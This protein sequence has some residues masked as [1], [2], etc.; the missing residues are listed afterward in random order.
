MAI[1]KNT[2]DEYNKSNAAYRENNSTASARNNLT[3]LGAQ[4]PQY[5]KSYADQLENIYGRL[6]N[7]ESC[8][9]D[10]QNDAAFRRYAD[11][12]N[13]LSGLA[14]AGNQQQAQQLTGGY[15]STYAPDVAEQG[16]ARLQSGV[17]GAQ[18]GFYNA[19]RQ[20]YMAENDRLNNMYSATA[21][22]RDAELEQ[23]QKQ[24][25]A[26]NNRYQMAQQRYADERDF[27]YNQYKDTRNYNASQYEFA[28]KQE[29]FDSELAQKETEYSRD[30]ELK[31][32]EVYTKLAAV[33]CAE[34]NEAKNNSGMKAYLDG[35]VEAG[36]I[37]Q[38]MADNLYNQYKYTVTSSG[39]GGGRSS[40]GGK[41]S[42]SS[43][44]YSY[45]GGD[46]GTGGSGGG[47][48]SGSDKTS[49]WIVAHDSIRNRHTHTLNGHESS[50]T[51]DGM[52][53]AIQSAYQSGEL[54][55]QEAAYLLNY[56]GLSGQAKQ[57]SSKGNKGG[58]GGYNGST[59]R[60][61]QER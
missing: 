14:I 44:S 31:S 2:E 54:S 51:A 30:Y 45:D 6:K 33:K 13:A 49:D 18:P 26:Y 36:K 27:G 48:F 16:L 8:N 25:D 7:G 60:T 19:A 38:Y 28:Q 1:N 52:T 11:E 41:K 29:Q 42:S 37:T 24:V 40:S 21:A 20:A 58:N 3:G 39:G 17:T 4:A 32:F 43:S 55:Q 61:T 10:P 12:Y 23:Y 56:Y 9:Y 34:Y 35:L 22:A 57:S 53:N 46:G 5:R 15:G 47:S 50:L 59:Y